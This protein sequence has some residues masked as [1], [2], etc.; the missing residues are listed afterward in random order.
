MLI[1]G[2]QGCAVRCGSGLGATLL[3]KLVPSLSF[4]QLG[5]LLRDGERMQ[6]GRSRFA[7]DRHCIRR[8]REQMLRH[9]QDSGAGLP[10]SL[11]LLPLLLL[12]P[13]VRFLPP[14]LLLRR[15]RGHL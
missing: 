13:M 6:P 12:L 15:S 2:A 4:C 7:G 8:A 14:L 1:K 11:T 5:R 9:Q 3:C 10:S